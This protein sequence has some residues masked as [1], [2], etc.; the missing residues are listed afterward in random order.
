MRTQ[1]SR[2]RKWPSSTSGLGLHWKSGSGLN[3]SWASR[4]GPQ[5]FYLSVSRLTSWVRSRSGGGSWQSGTDRS[6]RRIYLRGQST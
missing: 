5:G 2:R 1:R 6:G 4:S 3:R